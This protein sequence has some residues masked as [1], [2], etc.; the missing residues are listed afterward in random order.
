MTGRPSPTGWTAPPMWP[1]PPIHL[2]SS[3]PDAAPVRLIVRQGE[4][5]PRFPVGPLRQ[6]QLSRIHHR[7]GRRDPGTG[8]RPSAPR[9]DRERHPRPQVRCGSQPSTDSGRFCRQ[10][11]LAGGA[12]AIAHNLARWTGRIA[13]GEA[14]ATTP[15]PSGGASSPWPDASPARRAASPCISPRAGPGNASSVVP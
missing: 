3:E 7:P 1:K 8:G 10:R 2:S 14:V 11:R 13:L 5:H 15:R 9:R 12:D 4:T 6:L